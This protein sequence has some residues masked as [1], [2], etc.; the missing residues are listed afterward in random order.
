MS[1]EDQTYAQ[2]IARRKIRPGVIPDF[3]DYKKSKLE[4]L[5]KIENNR[6]QDIK[7]GRDTAFKYA[8]PSSIMESIFGALV[9]WFTQ[10]VVFIFPMILLVLVTFS[11]A[12]SLDL[13]KTSERLDIIYRTDEQLEDI[14]KQEEELVSSAW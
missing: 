9:A 4:T 8:L 2:S 6:L 10:D 11:L 1:D 3:L 5:E 12:Y 14:R 13:R 7:H